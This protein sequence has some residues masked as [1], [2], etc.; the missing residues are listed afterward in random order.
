MRVICIEF[1]QLLLTFFHLNYGLEDIHM[2][3][4]IHQAQN[5]RGIFL[6]TSLTFKFIFVIILTSFKDDTV[7]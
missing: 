2:S 1:Q 3:I 5:G 7:L 4:C 6:K